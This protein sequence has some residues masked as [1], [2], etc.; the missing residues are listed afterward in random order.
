MADRQWRVSLN[1]AMGANG[2]F[3]L[4]RCDSS[5]TYRVKTFINEIPTILPQCQDYACDLND[6]MSVWGPI[7]DN[8]D[9]EEICKWPEDDV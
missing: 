6:V 2:A 1:G 3:I 7:A 9:L 4:Y 8:C 5:P